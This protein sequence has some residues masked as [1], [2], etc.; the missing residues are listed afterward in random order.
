MITIY[1]GLHVLT[2]GRF[3]LGIDSSGSQYSGC[4]LMLND[5]T[6]TYGAFFDRADSSV[7]LYDT[8]LMYSAEADLGK[9]N[10]TCIL[11]QVQL[12][13]VAAM[14]DNS[15]YQNVSIAAGPDGFRIRDQI[16]SPPDRVTVSNSYHAVKFFYN[17]AMSGR[18]YRVTNLTINNCTNHIYVSS[19]NA[20]ESN[21]KLQL[22]DCV[23]LDMTKI[24]KGDSKTYT[25]CWIEEVYTI[26]YLITDKD[27]MPIP[28][29]KVKYI[30]DFGS[31]ETTSSPTFG[32]VY[33]EV[34]VKRYNI[35]SGSLEISAPC[36]EIISKPGYET[37]INKIVPYQKICDTLNLRHS[38]YASTDEKGPMHT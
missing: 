29:A 24:I 22:I 18:T 31:F 4:A 1:G 28:G 32:M 26:N 33:L 5:S 11:K 14:F 38:P 20:S 12:S 35:A 37:I 17:Y 19:P 23:G 25:N 21:F 34:P 10:N 6:N 13:E 9:S 8:K 15:I 3:K 36:T 27:G 16:T 7:E 30:N 2:K